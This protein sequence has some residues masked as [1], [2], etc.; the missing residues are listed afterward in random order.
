MKPILEEFQRIVHD[1]LPNELLPMRDIQHHINL[2]PGAS[3]PSLLHYRINP[4]E[5]KILREK[6]EELIQKR[7]IRENMSPCAVSAL[8]TSKKH[9]S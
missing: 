9:K 6:V 1:E 5:S 4:K 7:H 8:L 3:L 2:I